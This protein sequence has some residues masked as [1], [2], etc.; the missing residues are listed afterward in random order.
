MVGLGPSGRRPVL[1][2]RT[3]DHELLC[4]E[5]FPHASTSNRLSLRFK[6][7]RHGIIL[8]ERKGKGRKEQMAAPRFVEQSAYSRILI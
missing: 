2:G 6:K 5:A 7:M 4:Y 8:R 1:L 3:Q